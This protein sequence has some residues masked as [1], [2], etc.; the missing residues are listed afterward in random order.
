M[1]ATNSVLSFIEN[2]NI[3]HVKKLPG[4]SYYIPPE[5]QSLNGKWDFLF[6][7]GGLRWATAVLDGSPKKSQ[8]FHDKKW[9]DINVPGHWQLQGYSAPI[10]TNIN[11]PIPV[12]PPYV[13]AQNPTGI[14]RKSFRLDKSHK[15]SDRDVRIRFD[16]VDSAYYV[17]LNNSFVGFS[18]GSR[19]P[20]E[21]DIGRYVKSDEENVLFVVVVQ[22]SDGTYIEDQDQWWLSGIYRDVTVISYPKAAHIEDFFFDTVKLKK[23]EKEAL[24]SVHLVAPVLEKAQLKVE[25]QPK[26]ISSTTDKLIFVNSK[27]VDKGTDKHEFSFKINNALFWHP[28]EP[29]LYAVKITLSIKDE[30]VHELETHLG[31]RTTAIEDGLLR[32]NGDPVLL[33]GVNRHDHNAIRGRAVSE[34]DVKHD[35][36]LMKQY[37][38]NAIRCSHYPSHPKLL[39]WA[40]ILGFYVIDEADLE[41]HGFGNSFPPHRDDVK[42]PPDSE[43]SRTNPHIY[44]SAAAYTSDNFEWHN[45]YIDRAE[46]MTA[47]DKAHPSVIIW[48]LGNESFFGKN[49]V[50]MYYWLKRHFPRYPVHYEQD[51]APGDT[52]HVVDIFSKMYPQFGWLEWVADRLVKP[53]ILCEYGHAMGNG[54]GSL[55]EYMDLFYRFPKLQGGFIWEW[56]NHG[57]KTKIPGKT[58]EYYYAYGG[59]FGEPVNDSTFVMDGLNRSD[60][61]P[62]HSMVEYK[63]AI[64]P[65]SIDIKADSSGFQIEIINRHDWVSLDQY[66]FEAYVDLLPRYP[67]AAHAHKYISKKLDITGLRPAQSKTIKVDLDWSDIKKHEGVDAV[68]NVVFTDKKDQEWAKKGHL[69]GHS[70]KIL[71]KS[72]KKLSSE[73]ETSNTESTEA[74][75]LDEDLEKIVI[76]TNDDVFV[77]ISKIT[78]EITDLSVNDIKP[79]KLGP[80][81]PGIWRALTD[82]DK[83]NVGQYWKRYH[84]NHLHDSVQSVT[85]ENSNGKVRVKVVKYV[86]P[87]V[88]AWGMEAILNYEFEKTASGELSV[89]AKFEFTP[90]GNYPDSVPRIGLDFVLDDDLTELEWY[91]R[92]KES[93]A[94]SLE[95]AKLGL[96]HAKVSDLYEGY[97]VPQDNGNRAEVRWVKASSKEDKDISVTFVSGSNTGTHPSDTFNFEAQPWNAFQLDEAGHPYELQEKDKANNLR[98]DF[99][100]YPLGSESCGPGPLDKYRI[101]IR[102]SEYNAQ[103]IIKTGKK[104]LKKSLLHR[105]F[106]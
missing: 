38:I 79:I 56:A 6:S 61:T 60:H 4:R 30:V 7:E 64:Q 37:N 90:R 92:D 86:A 23:K 41:C 103:I 25:I 54:P 31:I 9:S 42:Q 70:Q 71:W 5:S 21:F 82:N 45:A 47:R 91:G 43:V 67:E 65:A 33:R 15:K 18:K 100:V 26:D 105:T 98:I 102:P 51:Q 80:V 88:L 99:E 32:V 13:P 44:D 59:D 69:I 17:Y 77:Q 85:G 29:N 11:F 101:F 74:L 72:E 1:S 68:A 19:N 84:V 34:E 10:Y 20:A 66:E 48:S 22:W 89:N 36:Y 83:A 94:D 53:L 93:Y 27:V 97:E 76:S 28:E 55:K 57:L 87:A 73:P 40:D 35:L 81:F 16:G 63:F 62:Y 3:L 24:V 75:E 58:D 52:T 2:P 14:Y 12:N 96:N 8:S 104:S 50:A 95:G 39:H 106:G 46:Q 49:H 78:G